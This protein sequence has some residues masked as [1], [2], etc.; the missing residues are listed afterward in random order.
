MGNV[1]FKLIER[2]TIWQAWRYGNILLLWT[3][4]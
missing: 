4:P 3:A 2:S 1:R